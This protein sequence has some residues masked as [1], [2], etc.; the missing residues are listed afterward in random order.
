MMLS[1]T[2]IGFLL[3]TPAIT[4]LAISVLVSWYEEKERCVMQD[5]IGNLKA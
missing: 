1:L 4:L 5:C 3:T 2:T